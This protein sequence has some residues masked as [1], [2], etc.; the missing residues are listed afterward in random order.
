M[1]PPHS[2]TFS[3]SFLFMFRCE[4]LCEFIGIMC[5]QDQQKFYPL[6]LLSIPTAQHFIKTYAACF[7]HFFLKVQKTCLVPPFSRYPP[8][9]ILAWLNTCASSH[10]VPAL[11]L[12]FLSF[13][14]FS[15]L[16]I[17]LFSE[18]VPRWGQLL[19]FLIFLVSH[20]LLNLTHIAQTVI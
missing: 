3:R 15:F 5:L 9:D 14:S 12:P 19:A 7:T 20:L 2:S 11:C 16:V 4:S 6:N 13:P 8:H 18:C 1:P 10:C 17:V